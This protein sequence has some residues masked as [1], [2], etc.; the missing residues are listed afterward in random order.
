MAQ[1]AGRAKL[2]NAGCAI[3]PEFDI[4]GKV[5][6]GSAALGVDVVWLLRDQHRTF[7]CFEEGG[8]L[9]H[10]LFRVA[11]KGQGRNGSVTALRMV[12]IQFSLTGHAVGRWGWRLKS[13]AANTKVA[14]SLAAEKTSLPRQD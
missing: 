8:Q 14:G 12:W 6:Q 4:V 2:N 9:L 3:K 11:G 7:L 13:A 5:Q 10:S 1:A